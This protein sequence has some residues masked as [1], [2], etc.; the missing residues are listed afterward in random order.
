MVFRCDPTHENNDTAT[1]RIFENTCVFTV[2]LHIHVVEEARLKTK[3]NMFYALRW[4]KPAGS[5]FGP[6]QDLDLEATWG[7]K[8]F[9][10]R[11]QKPFTKKV[12]HHPNLKGQNGVEEQVGPQGG[13]PSKLLTK[14]S[15]P[16]KDQARSSCLGAR[17]RIY[18]Y[19]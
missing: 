14:G 3:I 15:N 18:I 11:F 4:W 5:V 12:K 10:N 9:P 16:E 1:L 13:G 2:I 7:S 19:L 6:P 8:Y 17:W